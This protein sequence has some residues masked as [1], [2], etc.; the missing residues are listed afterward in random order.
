[1]FD[2]KKDNDKLMAKMDRQSEEMK[3]QSGQLTDL[4]I[5]VNKIANKLDTCAHI[6]TDDEFADR[7]VL[8]KKNI[9]SSEY[10]V[11]RSQERSINKIINEKTKI[12]YMKIPDLIKSETIPNSIYLWNTIKDVLVKEHQIVCKYNDIML[13]NITESDFIMMIKQ[14]FDSR[15]EYH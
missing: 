15:K 8:M 6:P 13:N 10:Y 7:F 4:Q 1:M 2:L 9:K 12:G 11:I 14:V 5:T 3:V